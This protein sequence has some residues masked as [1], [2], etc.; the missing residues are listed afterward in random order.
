MSYMKHVVDRIDPRTTRR[1]LETL[2]AAATAYRL[3]MTTNGG[4][5]EILT[6]PGRQNDQWGVQ[7]EP[8]SDG[9]GPVHAA[10]WDTYEVLGGRVNMLGWYDLDDIAGC[11][12]AFRRWLGSR[13]DWQT[14]NR[15]LGAAAGTPRS[16]PDIWWRCTSH[17]RTTSGSNRDWPETPPP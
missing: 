6:G 16:S 9:T 1:L 7:Y 3:D 4:Y 12:A 2:Q 8:A 11:A 15:R 13:V 5:A 17:D 10:S 14:T